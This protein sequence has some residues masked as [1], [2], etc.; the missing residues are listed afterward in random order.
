MHAALAEIDAIVVRDLGQRYIQRLR[1]KGGNAA[2]VVDRATLRECL[3]RVGG[4]AVVRGYN[5]TDASRATNL[6]GVGGGDPGMRI[7]YVQLAAASGRLQQ[8][9]AS[10]A[11]QAKEI[12]GT[13]PRFVSIAAFR[14]INPRDEADVVLAECEIAKFRELFLFAEADGRSVDILRRE[15]AAWADIHARDATPA[16]WFAPLGGVPLAYVYDGESVPPEVLDLH[17]DF[18]PVSFI[19]AEDAANG[20]FLQ[21]I[22]YRVD[23]GLQPLRTVQRHSVHREGTDFV[24]RPIPP[25]IGDAVA[26][27]FE[28]DNISRPIFAVCHDRYG[29]DFT[30]ART[31]CL[32]SRYA[33]RVSTERL[34]GDPLQFQCA[35]VAPN[36]WEAHCRPRCA[37]SIYFA[38]SLKSEL[39]QPPGQRT[40]ATSCPDG[41]GLQLQGVG[42]IGHSDSAPEPQPLVERRSL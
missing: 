42:A 12:P 26:E 36:W 6:A 28:S 35:I 8:V 32:V 38:F 41:F 14:G 22:A 23:C 25:V 3:G 39:A 34:E 4:I 33:K 24:S 2:R 27:T 29:A 20:T 21:R 13:V 7:V 9:R 11:A 15:H 18:K 40:A 30:A 19:R 5:S 17:L 1:S 31:L 37:G 10:L 16:L